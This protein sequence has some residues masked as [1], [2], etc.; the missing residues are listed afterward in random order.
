MAAVGGAV[1]GL[2]TSAFVRCVLFA[3]SFSAGYHDLMRVQR[4]RRSCCW[5]AASAVPRAFSDAPFVSR[6]APGVWPTLPDFCLWVSLP[7]LRNIRTPVVNSN[8]MSVSAPNKNVTLLYFFLSPF[9]FRFV[10]G[11][12]HTFEP[13]LLA[14]LVAGCLA[15][16]GLSFCFLYP[17]PPPSPL[18]IPNFL[19]SSSLMSATI[20]VF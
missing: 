10:Y 14:L 15:G 5:W 11:T 7:V 13:S 18:T 1:L 12:V 19:L 16:F 2:S 6:L 20:I 17:L 9:F 4:T 8:T 3:L